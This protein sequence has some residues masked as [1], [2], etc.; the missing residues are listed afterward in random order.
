MSLVLLHCG[1]FIFLRNF[2]LFLF[3]SKGRNSELSDNLQKSKI[4]FLLSYLIIKLLFINQQL[5]LH[6]RARLD[7][8]LQKELESH[9][10]LIRI[11]L[12]LFLSFQPFPVNSYGIAYL[13]DSALCF[14]WLIKYLNYILIVKICLDCPNFCLS[15][16]R[17]TYR[18]GLSNKK[19]I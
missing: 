5:S 12:L 18:A 4:V 8:F 19:C 17:H 11:P 2:Q 10:I 9:H 14:L 16:I 13:L 3:V 7:S 1:F 15:Q 6:H